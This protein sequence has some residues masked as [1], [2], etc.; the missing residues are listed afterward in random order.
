MQQDIIWIDV[1]FSD[2]SGS[3]LRPALV[4]SNNGY[5]ASGLDVVICGITSNLAEQPHSVPI[6]QHNLIEGYLPMLSRIKSDKLSKIEKKL[7]K[8]RIGKLNDETFDLVVAEIN[9][10]ITRR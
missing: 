2:F 3:K 5:N 1:P 8:K 9:D 4:V 10:L 7:I 6:S